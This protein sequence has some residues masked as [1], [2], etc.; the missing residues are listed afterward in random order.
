MF[1]VSC[2]LS[3][4][5]YFLSFLLLLFNN[6]KTL[7]RALSAEHLDTTFLFQSLLPL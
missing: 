3:L 7:P 6:L 2:S 1:S 5:P 4:A